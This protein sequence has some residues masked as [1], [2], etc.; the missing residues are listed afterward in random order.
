V[1][2]FRSSTEESARDKASED[3]IR[4]LNATIP[5]DFHAKGNLFVFV[6]EAHRTQSGKMHKAM[7][8]LLPHAMFIGFTGTPL[9]KADKATSI[10]TFGS[11]IHTY[12]F[13]EA[14]RDGV[15]VDL[16]YEARNIDQH[17]TSPQ[18]VD[19]WFDAKTKGMTDLSKAV[20][21]K[22]WGTMQKVVS[23]EPR[24]KQIVQD[25]LIDMETK[26]R[27]MDG[28]GNTL[29]VGA[30]IYQACKF[31]LYRQEDARPRPIPGHLP[32]QPARRRGQGL[33]LYRRLPGPVQLPGVG[34][35]GLHVRR[36]GRLRAAGR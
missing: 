35:H 3:F 34:N 1:H 9:L 15:V 32:G 17:L 4:E 36:P 26:P 28:R 19:R 18:Q 30:S 29:L 23:S 27:L 13:D 14:V 21:K 20:L 5:K 22:R 10:E 33:R 24:A 16:R 7:K 12:K 25:I 8:R 6:D 2:K 31:Y 11:F